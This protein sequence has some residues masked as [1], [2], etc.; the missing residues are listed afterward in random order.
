[1]TTVV[2]KGKAFHTSQVTL[3][4]ACLNCVHDI[5]QPKSHVHWY[6]LLDA[7]IEQVP[8]E[9]HLHPKAYKSEGIKISSSL[10]QHKSW[11]LSQIHYFPLVNSLVIIKF[12]KPL[13][14]A[15]FTLHRVFYC[16][17]RTPVVIG[18]QQDLLLL[19][20]LLRMSL[21]RTRCKLR[22]PRD[23]RT[24]QRFT[25]FYNR[26]GDIYFLFNVIYERQYSYIK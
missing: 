26:N 19:G 14:S 8:L 3:L 24:H 23:A 21:R 18:C 20:R 25:E 10:L 2:E 5:C 9:F 4:P 13:T 7:L 1:M 12:S 11:E 16:V 15:T 22:L 17:A 6:K